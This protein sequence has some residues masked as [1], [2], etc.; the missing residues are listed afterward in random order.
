MEK[1]EVELGRGSER[2]G[3]MEFTLRENTIMNTI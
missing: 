3:G 1:E 2:A